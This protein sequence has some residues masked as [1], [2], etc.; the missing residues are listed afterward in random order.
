[1]SNCPSCNNEVPAGSRWCPICHQNV[2]GKDLGTLASPG[3][4]L[5]A[6]LLDIIVP[7]AALILFISVSGI[8]SLADKGEGSGLRILLAVAVLS[9]YVIW[10]F[11]LFARATTPGKK[12]LGMRVVKENGNR[13]GFLT[14]LFREV[15]GKFISAIVVLL[16]FIWILFDKEN[17]G[18]HDKL[19]STYVI[20]G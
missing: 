10:A 13:A 19:A 15:I 18:W 12:I 11:I 1:M 6:H 3:R 17:Q 4:R 2:I 5:G 14:M 7:Y 8:E 16:G 9:A 20:K